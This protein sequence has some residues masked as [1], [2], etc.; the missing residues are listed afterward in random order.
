M[1]AENWNST[2]SPIAAVKEFGEKARDPPA[3]TVTVWTDELPEDDVVAAA[4][5]DE[6][7][8]TLLLELPYCASAPA[9]KVQSS[10]RT[11]VLAILKLFG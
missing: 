2:W 7:L 5:G 10:V 4:D 9:M 8:A 11:D 6:E 1:L 3:P